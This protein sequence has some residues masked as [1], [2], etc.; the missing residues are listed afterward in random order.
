MNWC[1]FGACAGCIPVLLGF[2]ESYRRLNID[3]GDSS[4]DIQEIQEKDITKRLQAS[5]G[6]LFSFT[7]VDGFVEKL[8]KAKESDI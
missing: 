5:I 2:R 4:D 1:M 7:Q 6:S 8:R 3:N